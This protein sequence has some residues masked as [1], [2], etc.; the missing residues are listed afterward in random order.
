[1]ARTKRRSRRRNGFKIPIA[2][3]AG[4]LPG[5]TRTLTITQQSGFQAGSYEAARIYTGYDPSSGGW[6]ASYLWFGLAP[7][8]IG[9]LVHKIAGGIGLNRALGRAGIPL[10]RI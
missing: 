2:I 9:F 10:V 1:M 4:F 8:V 7:M 5:V 3:V 6:R